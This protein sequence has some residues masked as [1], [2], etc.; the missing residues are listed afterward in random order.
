LFNE[1]ANHPGR[2]ALVQLALQTGQPRV[3]SVIRL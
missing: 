1:K 3:G 2:S